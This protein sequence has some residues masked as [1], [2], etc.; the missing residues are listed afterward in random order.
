M[1]EFDSKAAT[2][3]ENPG[4]I[5]RAKDIAAYM[6]EVLDLSQFNNAL[7]YGSG[8]G[9]LSFE[10]RGRI[11][12]ITLMD[13]SSEMIKMADMKC[14]ALNVDNINSVHCDLLEDSLPITKYDLV[15]TLL[16]LHHI[17]NVERVLFKFN[18][19]LNNS[20]VL[21]IIDLVKEDGSCHDGNFHGHHGFNKNEIEQ[22]L[23]KAGFSTSKYEVCYELEKERNGIKRK[24]P[25]FMLVAEKA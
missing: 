4:R 23:K 3:D 1:S 10:L 15:Y 21:V 18:D 19:I 25:L 6:S 9:L 5:K 22:G 16:T 20:G 17:M 8:T 14:K 12:K 11:P 2:W 24:Y 13:Q 7:E